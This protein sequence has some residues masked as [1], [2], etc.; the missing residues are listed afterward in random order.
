MDGMPNEKTG[1]WQ[2]GRALRRAAFSAR[3][4]EG[5]NG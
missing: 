2:S 4:A 5:S 1:C 3:G